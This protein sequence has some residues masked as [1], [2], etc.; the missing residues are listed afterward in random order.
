MKKI[1]FYFILISSFLFISSE[2]YFKSSSQI[3]IK[4]NNDSIFVI[5]NLDYPSKF[6]LKPS[7]NGEFSIKTYKGDSII[8]IEDSS[9][10]L[11][12][13]F[14]LKNMKINDILEYKIDVF[15]NY[16]MDDSLLVY[17]KK[18]FSVKKD[19]DSYSKLLDFQLERSYQKA[20]SLLEFYYL[21]DTTNL[22]IIY[23]NSVVLKDMNKDDESFNLLKKA[24]NYLDTTDISFNIALELIFDYE[25]LDTKV[26]TYILDFTYKN[27]YRNEYFI[28]VLYQSMDLY[29]K[30]I[31][32][33]RILKDMEKLL[34]YEI[35][36]DARFS[37]C[38]F[39]IDEG[40]EVEKS[41]QNLVSLYESDIYGSYGDWLNY[42]LAKGYLLLKDY[43][44]CEKYL[45]VAE[46]EFS[47]KEREIYQIGFDYGLATDDMEKIKTYGVKLLSE[48]IYDDKILQIVEKKI[49]LNRKDIEKKVYDY[50]RSQM[51]TFE[52]PDF[53]VEGL[54]GKKK[55]ISRIVKGKVTI[56]NFFSSNCPYCKKEIPILN[57]IK[58]SFKKN[59]NF[60][61][62]A[63]S[64]D[65]QIEPL[66]RFI[67]ETN[68]SYSIFYKGG[69][70]MDSLKIEGVPTIFIVDREQKVRF[71][72]VGYFDELYGY[73]K[74]RMEF[75]KSLK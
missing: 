61:F 17:L 14:F 19:Y 28:Y 65:N 24:V 20:D 45:N 40:Y 4:S 64:S 59:K 13:I 47:M 44:E 32:D 31:I 26:L 8:I 11:M 1:L 57:K 34:D 37:V 25:K 38:A 75:L 16:N 6:T 5:K 63:I 53:E 68:F 56:L 12:D 67:N 39:F 15:Q 33:N 54:D 55:N 10:K 9:E 7:K 29:E 72:K 21:S 73:L 51:D 43:E 58:E 50:L 42:Y 36:D 22:N 60:E 52:F 23:K 62:L 71:V 48:N 30:K 66:K 69:L 46:N 41:I 2:N 74:T 35:S 18:S 70:L 49:G 27:F 3:K